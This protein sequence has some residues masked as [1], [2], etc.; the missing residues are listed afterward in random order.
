VHARQLEQHFAVTRP[1]MPA[2]MTHVRR[3]DRIP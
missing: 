2:P 1:E 3:I